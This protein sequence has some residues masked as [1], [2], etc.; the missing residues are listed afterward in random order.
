MFSL[1]LRKVV[2]LNIYPYEWIELIHF[3]PFALTPLNARDWFGNLSGF[4]RYHQKGKK[5]ER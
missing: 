5:D 2:V 1:V 3:L 4:E